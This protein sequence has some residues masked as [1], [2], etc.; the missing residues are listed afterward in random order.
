MSIQSAKHQ[1]L[2]E[3][4]RLRPTA[5]GHRR[6][7]LMV[8]IPLCEGSDRA[9][10]GRV[11]PPAELLSATAVDAMRG[12]SRTWCTRAYDVGDRIPARSDLARPCQRARCT[13]RS[14]HPDEVPLRLADDSR[15][16]DHAL[17]KGA[18]ARN[19]GD[20]R[21]A[22][23]RRGVA[24]S[25]RRHRFERRHNW[26]SASCRMLHVVASSA[27]GSRYDSMNARLTR[28]FTVAFG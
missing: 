20:R 17:P 3:R 25:L 7:L 6:Q 19:A 9:G 23:R 12:S 13:E 28:L 21:P 4:G 5:M 16:L 24:P 1:H 18:R 8:E 2:V 15:Y 14:A 22:H 11:S 26:P 10:I 27:A